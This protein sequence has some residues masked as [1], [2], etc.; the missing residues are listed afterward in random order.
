[1]ASTLRKH[2]RA[3]EHRELLFGWGRT[4]PTAADVQRPVVD[5]ELL[6]AFEDAPA[7]GVLA[8]GMGRSYGDAALNSGGRVIET[9]ELSGIHLDPET[10][11]CT[12]S[13]G[14]SIDQLIR[15]LVP[16]GFF[17]PVTPGTRYVSVGGAVAAD[18]HG[19]NHHA[20]GSWCDHVVSM[21]LLLPSGELVEIS[22]D[23]RPDLF[24]ATAGGLGL[25]GI[26]VDCTFRCRPIETSRLLVE[27]VRTKDLD[28]TLDLMRDA[29]T[30]Y[31]VAWIDHLPRGAGMG[32]AIVDFG[33]FA[34]VDDLPRAERSEPL[35][36]DGNVLTVAPPV[37]PNGLLNYATIRAFNEL[38]Y[39]KTR[40]HSV[41]ELKTIAG[42]FHPLDMIGEWN[43][44][45]GTQ[46]FVQ[47]QIA[48]PFNAED[49]LV[50]AIDRLSR[51]RLPSFVNVLKTF[52]P[53]NDGPLSFPIGG[54][55][56]AVDIPTATPD[57]PTVL[58]RL[59]DEVAEAGGRVYLAKDSRLRAELV[60]VMYPRLDEWRE[61]QAQADPQGQLRS[62]LAR[63]LRLL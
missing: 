5:D 38:W 30:T 14:V 48:V 35:T 44:A 40:G 9:T 36:Y 18:I 20:V 11:L 7:R 47:W 49:T 28:T 62:D 37:I 39:R 43:R 41:G 56:L 17:V 59:D 25:T 3:P 1:M 29:P 33:D 63:R 51:E 2:P 8:R 4:A 19:K 24:W 27:T 58:D 42:Y 46:G 15:V 60:P 55:T 13:A 54:W 34:A 12:A 52:G 31:S 21:R 53:A 23:V 57:L 32:R 50:R 26:V 22:R 16:R 61:V 10:G 6:T 45:Y